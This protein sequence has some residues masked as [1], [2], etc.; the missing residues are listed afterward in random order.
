FCHPR[1]D[2]DVA[3][4]LL[5]VMQLFHEVCFL[6]TP[7][8]RNARDSG[9]AVRAMTR[10]ANTQLGAEFSIRAGIW[11]GLTGICRRGQRGQNDQDAETDPMLHDYPASPEPSNYSPR[12][13][14]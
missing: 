11:Q 10:G 13:R 7:D 12:N 4:A 6:L 1:H 2:L 3:F 5:E 8:D 9:Y 14:A